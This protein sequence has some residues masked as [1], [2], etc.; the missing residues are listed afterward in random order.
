LKT[1][2]KTFSCRLQDNVLSLI[3]QLASDSGKSQSAV[4]TR[5]IQMLANVKQNT[6]GTYDNVKQTENSEILEEFRRQL[7]VKDDLIHNQTGQINSL[8]RQNDQSQQLLASFTLVSEGRLLEHG[9]H[10]KQSKKQKKKFKKGKK[11]NR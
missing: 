2:S 5:A 3:R 9:K 6:S 10:K 1:T 4:I 8:I 7:Q 11:N